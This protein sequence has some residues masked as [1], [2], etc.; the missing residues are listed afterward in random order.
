MRTVPI[1]F[2]FDKR[3]E[4][5]AGV[6]ISSLLANADKDTFYDI[7]ILHSSRLDFS[8]S[9]IKDLATIFGN[10][11]ISFRPVIDEFV[12][13]FEIRG[14]TETCYYR[15]LIPELIPEYDKILYSDVD[16]IFRDDLSGFYDTP[17]DDC[18]FASVNSVPVMNE[19]YLAYIKMRGIQAGEGYYYSGNLIINSAKL[20]SD[21]KLAEFRS[22]QEMNYRFQDMDIIN[23]TCRGKIKPLPPSFCLTNNYY[24]AL[25]TERG[26]MRGYFSDAEID[27]AL[28]QGILHYNGA[29]PWNEVCPNMDIWWE[30]YRKSIFFDEAFTHDFWFNQTYRIERMSLWKRIK[31]V[32]RYFRKGGRM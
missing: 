19:D 29:K 23:L 13:A 14:I 17:M 6:A 10:C 1:A 22:H 30:Y 32:A 15:L 27:E 4:M 21:G 3:M 28:Q 25:V 8:G 7:F 2:A 18:Y 12:G 16:V 5:P 24:Q 26:R 20:L 31:Q 9:R 11:R